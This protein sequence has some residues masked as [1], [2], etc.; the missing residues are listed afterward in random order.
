M[1]SGREA[2][3]GLAVVGVAVAV[4]ALYFATASGGAWDDPV[5]DADTNLALARQLAAGPLAEPYWQP[6]LH[7]WLLSA[8]LR[9]SASLWLP[10]IVVAALSCAAA[11]L[12]YSLALRATGRRTPSWVAGGLVALNGPLLYYD[13]DLL[14]TSLGTFLAVLAVWLAARLR[15]GL[16]RAGAVGAVIGLAT[17]AVGP[18]ALLVLPLALFTRLRGADR[19]AYAVV[20]ASSLVAVLGPALR[21]NHGTGGGLV[22]ATSG[23][24]NL[25]IGNNPDMNATVAVR[26]GAGWEHLADE[27]VRVGR[28]RG[29]REYDE[30]F[31]AK[32]RA[33]CVESPVR[34][35]LGVLEKARQ[36][37][38]S[39]EIP[40]N[41]SLYVARHQSPVLEALV[42][43][44]GSVG[45]PW[46]V[47]FPLAAAGLVRAW[48]EPAQGLGRRAD[49]G[50]LRFL[51]LALLALAAGPLVF[52]V[53]GRYRVP[54]V[55]L[56][57]IFAAV[58]VDGLLR[59]A[60][61]RQGLAA[62]LALALAVW[63]LRVPVESVRYD[64]ELDYLV[65]GARE[66]RG[67]LAGAQRSLEAALAARPDYLEAAVNL[68]LL[69]HRQ[70]HRERA[71]HWI[72]VALRHHP[73]DATALAVLRAITP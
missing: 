52:F 22:V 39:P 40:R 66:R 25:F 8:A 36:L 24:I 62:T 9:V 64:A 23:G 53:T 72:D 58:G 42:W 16:V 49:P 20:A 31:A 3:A 50:L 44:V 57:A 38:A 63:P 51:S 11:W 46:I 67:D 54:L 10:R 68:A 21:H 35:A 7:P 48:I 37:A 32:A 19:V 41:E 15:D 30:Y 59:H 17:L 65:A 26:P 28:V 14:P 45:F 13:G 55:P 18:L 70:G 2:G 71:Q 60:T 27:P 47:L 5:L 69:H 34:C 12:T 4:R 29:A 73:N 56:V 1:G 33:F 61:P 6:P 43:R